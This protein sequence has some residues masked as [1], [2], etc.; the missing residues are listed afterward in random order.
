MDGGATGDG[1]TTGGG[2]ITGDGE[3]AAASVR[4]TPNG[5]RPSNGSAR[6]PETG[7]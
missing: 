3:P 2:E 7:G 5:T 1:G 6:P 4:R